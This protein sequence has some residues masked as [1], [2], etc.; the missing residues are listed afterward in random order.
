MI[1]KIFMVNFTIFSIYT[2]IDINMVS[3]LRLVAGI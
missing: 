2:T 1:L 3:G